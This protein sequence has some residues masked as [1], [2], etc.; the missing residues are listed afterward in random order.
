M[1]VWTYSP[2]TYCAACMRAGV[3][4]CGDA[5]VCVRCGARMRLIFHPPDLVQIKVIPVE[6]LTKQQRAD[7]HDLQR[8]ETPA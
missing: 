4:G 7:L 5:T 1:T 8:M 3:W 2:T 6:K